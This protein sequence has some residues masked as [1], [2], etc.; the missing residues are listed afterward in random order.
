MF[1]FYQFGIL[2]TY[3]G[4]SGNSG[5]DGASKEW[6][7]I[8]NDNGRFEY[9]IHWFYSMNSYEHTMSGSWTLNN[10]TL[11][12]KSFEYPFILNFVVVKANK[13]VPI[14]EKLL[15]HGSAYN[16]DTLVKK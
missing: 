16:L 9:N 6:K 14:P 5:M 2:G 4:K 11:T 12:L 7:L 13:L 1:P 15:S 8:L 10:D 3:V